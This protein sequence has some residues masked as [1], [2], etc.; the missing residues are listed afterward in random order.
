MRDDEVINVDQPDLTAAERAASALPV[1][2]AEFTSLWPI[3]LEPA[4]L[5]VRL[6]GVGPEPDPADHSVAELEG[7]HDRPTHGP[8]M[9]SQALVIRREGRA[10]LAQAC[11]DFLPARAH[12]DILGWDDHDIFSHASA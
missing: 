3:G 10:E 8:P 4:E 5:S 7:I 12:L 2:Q 1:D 9:G 6:E 11:F